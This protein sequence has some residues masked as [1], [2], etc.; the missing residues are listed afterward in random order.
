MPALSDTF[1]LA[2]GVH[3]PKIG[4]GTWQIPEGEAA[5]AA[6][7]YAL[8]NGYRHID[9]ARAYGNER[10]V[11]RAVRDSGLPREAVF[12][13]SK[14]PA[15]VKTAEGARQAIE[16]TMAALDLGHLDLYLVHAPWPWSDIGRD[17]REGNRIVWKVLE[18]FYG[19]GRCRAIG[20]SNFDVADLASLQETW[21]VV[22]L[23]NQI[24]VYVGHAQDALTRHCQERGILVEGYSP[25]AT[26]ALVEHAKLAALARK[27]GATVPRVCIRY[28]L[29]R[30]VLPLP[31]STHPEYIRQNADVDFELDADDM[32]Y[33]DGLDGIVPIT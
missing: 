8:E 11:G 18:D 23:V 5:Y 28:L 9:T 4:L 30:D 25:L 32:A 6:V 20:V 14:L 3:V 16:S 17:C 24:K 1:T 12:V 10:S 31:K 2:N 7:R 21:E 15:E 19:S 26:G 29:Q 13:T 22:P 33:L 27:H